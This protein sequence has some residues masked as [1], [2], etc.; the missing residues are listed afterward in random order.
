MRL[1]IIIYV[2]VIFYLK[3]LVLDMFGTYNLF[4]FR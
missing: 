4:G 2:F 1:K 3:A